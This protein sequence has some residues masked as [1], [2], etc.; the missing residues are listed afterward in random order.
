[1]EIKKCPNKVGF[2]RGCHTKFEMEAPQ[3]WHV[4]TD[5]QGLR[6]NF[7][8]ENKIGFKVVSTI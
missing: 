4:K 6:Q 5:K 8:R 2:K 7:G 1:L 3:T